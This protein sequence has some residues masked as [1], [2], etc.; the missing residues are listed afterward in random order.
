MGLDRNTLEIAQNATIEA[1]S[2]LRYAGVQED[3]DTALVK[4]IEHLVEAVE[5]LVNDAHDVHSELH[6][7]GVARN[8]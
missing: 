7:L 4:A 6:S 1:T 3:R 2:V 5:A 8:P